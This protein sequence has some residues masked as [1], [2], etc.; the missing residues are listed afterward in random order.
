MIT[1]KQKEI[2]SQKR[3]SGRGM[4]WMPLL[5]IGSAILSDFTV[6]ERVTGVFESYP[7]SMPICRHLT[8]VFLS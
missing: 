1:R 3:A 5:M 6:L 2:Y 8:F 7:L 4:D